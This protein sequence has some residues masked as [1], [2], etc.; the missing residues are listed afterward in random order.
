MELIRGD[1]DNLEGRVVIYSK[2]SEGDIEYHGSVD[3]YIED[4]SLFVRKCHTCDA[5]EIE[6]NPIIKQVKENMKEQKKQNPIIAHAK[7]LPFSIEA[8]DVYSEEEIKDV[9]G[10]ILYT[11]EF[12]DPNLCE[13]ANV[14]GVM[15]Y[16]FR[17]FNQENAPWVDIDPD[18]PSYRTISS[19]RLIEHVSNEYLSVMRSYVEKGDKASFNV[20]N[21]R[22]RSFAR[23]SPFEKDVMDLSTMLEYGNEPDQDMI[24]WSLGVMASKR[25]VQE[26]EEAM[27]QA[28]SEQDFEE[29]ARLRNKISRLKKS[30]SK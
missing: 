6:D 1:W 16:Q 5:N 22:F 30:I 21:K 9:P 15:I 11:G 24:S 25:K 8:F 27:E 2:F 4:G 28:V 20:I 23:G 18:E 19:D 12:K 3:G 17:L 10:D 7:I 14:M 26:I 13:Q 29:A